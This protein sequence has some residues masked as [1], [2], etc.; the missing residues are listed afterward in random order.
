[1]MFDKL[2]AQGCLK[3]TTSFISFIYL[4]F[5]IWKNLLNGTWKGRVVVD[6]WA[7]NKIIMLNTYS[8]PSQADILAA[9]Q[10]VKYIFTV[11]CSSFFY[12]WRVKQAHQH[13]LTVASHWGQ[14]IFKIAVMRY[15]NSSAYVQQMINRI[16]QQQ[17]PYVRVYVN[18]IVIFFNTLEEHLNHLHNIF[19]ILNKMRI[20]LLSKKFYLAYLSV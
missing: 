14:K 17:R 9:V 12:Q 11:D 2:Q 13:C 19:D 5:M 7:L 10:E 16:L 3:W 18:N 15:W 8:V 1:M 4:C 6:I 20:C